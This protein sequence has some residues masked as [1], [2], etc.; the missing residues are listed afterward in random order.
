[1]LKKR[2]I[3]LLLWRDGRLVKTRNFGSARVVGDPANTSRVYSDQDADELCILDIS[4][5]NDEAERFSR[6]VA[7]I[8]AETMVPLTV[9]GRINSLAKAEQAFR[10]GADKI[11]VNTLCFTSPELVCEMAETFG[12]QAVVAGIDFRKTPEGVYLFSHN[13]R[14]PQNRSLEQHLGEL[15]HMA[16]GEVLLQSIDKDGSGDGYDLGTLADAVQNTGVPVICGGGAG[17]YGHLLEAFELGAEAV[18]CGTLFNF[19][20]NNPIRAKAFLRSRGIPLKTSI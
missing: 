1:M 17:N 2:I 12:S 16:V 6:V 19:G 14:K 13:G 3:P 8:A 7:V 20:D 15:S 5:S 4:D 11:L 18:A 9:G 10:L